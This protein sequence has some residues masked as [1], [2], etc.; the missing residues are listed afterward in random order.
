MKIGKR[1]IGE[2]HPVYFIAELS[3]NHLQD[4]DLAVKTVRAM[5]KSG[6]DCLKL[7]TYTADT[8]TLNSDKEPFRIGGGTLWDGMTLHRL[9]EEANTP[10]DWHQDL[11]QIAREE[12]MECFSS[13]F[14]FSST[15]F[16]GSLEV[17][18]Y[19][20]AS[21]E[22]TDIPL[23]EYTASKMKPILIST[24]VAHEEDIV[25]AVAACRKAGN[26]DIALL[27]CVSSYPA[28]LSE[29]NLR[30]IPDMKSRFD[31][32]VGLSDH[33]LSPV[34]AVVATSL[35]ASIIEKHFILDRN[36]GGHDAAFSLEPDE[37]KEMVDQVRSAETALGT[38]SYT[39]SER[40]EKNR[41][42]AR[43]IF[44]S[45]DIKKGEKFSKENIRIIRPSGGLSPKF[46]PEILGKTAIRNLSAGTPLSGEDIQ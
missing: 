38:V 33:S 6:A 32:T 14:D 2:G 4:F 23:I 3:C 9:Y 39:L 40:A 28:P 17:P 43:S 26:N 19:K 25:D 31:V 12:G 13:P 11:I 46:Y 16:L 37:F 5:A 27:R 18:A 20:I 36:L 21:F 34:P 29:M 1:E 45:R 15:D 10:W 8:M 42:F 30:T 24:G 41:Q 35:G 22:I 7:Q 44:V